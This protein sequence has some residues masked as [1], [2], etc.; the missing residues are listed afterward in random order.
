VWLSNYCLVWYAEQIP[1][2]KDRVEGGEVGARERERGRGGG[3]TERAV[4]RNSYWIYGVFPH[5]H[6][7]THTHTMYRVLKQ[8]LILSRRSRFL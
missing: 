5:P 4:V 8:L 7:H 6:T 1:E 3:E 2:T